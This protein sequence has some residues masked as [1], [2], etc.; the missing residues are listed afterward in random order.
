M[1]KYLI[2]GKIYKYI[3]IIILIIFKLLAA[4]NL[5]LA[6]PRLDKFVHALDRLGDR[7]PSFHDPES[8]LYPYRHRHFDEGLSLADQQ[9]L[10][11]LQRSS[12][13]SGQIFDLM[14]KGFFGLYPHLKPL[15]KEEDRYLPVYYAIRNSYPA[16]QERCIYFKNKRRLE[17]WFDVTQFQPV[18]GA[19]GIKLDED[20]VSDPT[21]FLAWG[22]WQFWA[23]Y[24]GTL[25]LCRSYPPSV[26]DVWAS[27]G[28][29]GGL[30]YTVQE[31]VYLTGRADAHGMLSEAELADHVE[32]FRQ[33]GLT[34]ADIH[35]LLA[36]ARA[37]R[38][39]DMHFVPGNWQLICRN[40][41]RQ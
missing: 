37:K 15:M 32:Q 23:R 14:I 11:R 1:D 28:Q 30:S 31:A 27:A 21:M 33:Q 18:N 41:H 16:M 35:G 13:C 12:D 34:T 19:Y 25:A 2:V 5:T 39:Q 40:W 36:Q 24:L 22:R 17:R 26:R 9:I 7:D 38:L 8:P 20:E 29:Y 6:D 10:D 4:T 3:F